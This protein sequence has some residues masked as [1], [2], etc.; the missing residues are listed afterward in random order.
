MPDTPDQKAAERIGLAI[1][2]QIL[3]LADERTVL[4]GASARIAEIDAEL[5]EL[6]REKQR[7][8]PRRPPRLGRPSEPP[9]VLPSRTR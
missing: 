3:R 6:N 8:D 4:L 2:D 5:A 9:P 1:D 7:I